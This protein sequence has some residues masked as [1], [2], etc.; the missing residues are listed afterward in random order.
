[1][2]TRTAAVLVLLI[3]LSSISAL[4][5]SEPAAAQ[6]T[7]VTNNISLTYLNVQLTYPSEINPGQ[8]FAVNVQAN[9]KNTFTLQSLTLQIYYG[10]GTSLHSVATATVATN[11]NMNNGNKINKDIQATVPAD[12]LR[13]SLI[14]FVSESVKTASTGYSSNYYYS[15]Y[16]YYDYYN[17]NYTYSC[18]DYYSCYYSSYPYYN[19]Y[20]YPYYSYPSYSTYYTSSTDSGLG[21]LSYIN[22]TTPEYI[23]LQSQY[24][25]LQ[26]QLSQSQSQNQQLQ[27]NLQNAQNQVSQKDATISD[28]NNQLAST[29]NNVL[30]FE[31]ASGVLAVIAI[32]LGVGLVLK[33]RGNTPKKTTG[34]SGDPYARKPEQ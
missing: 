21:S 17:P 6:P 10:D 2:K 30:T 32:I 7:Q 24:Q 9:A 28:L 18:Y 29:H 14:A 27:Q 1:M 34:Q 23:S 11:M 20:Y 3:A 26:Q 25:A 22:A 12:A 5:L 31:I 33:G 19:S 4:T 13:T 15:Y 16:P 8:A